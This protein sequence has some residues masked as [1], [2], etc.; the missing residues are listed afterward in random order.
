MPNDKN[1]QILILEKLSE[2][3]ER[4]SRIEVEQRY[5][6]EDLQKVSEQDLVQNRLLEEHIKG[7]QTANARLDNEII[8]RETLQE[9][10]Q[11]RVS[12]LEIAPKFRATLK[13]YII[14]VG[15]VAGAVVGII[16]L[17]K[18]TGLL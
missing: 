7:V 17:L 6:K 9:E 8:M 2:I 3:G 5:M 18:M 10:F 13:Q 14:G 15:A 1:F 16:K 11:S 4:T 12:V